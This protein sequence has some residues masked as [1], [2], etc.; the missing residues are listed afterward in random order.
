MALLLPLDWKIE[1]RRKIQVN[2]LIKDKRKYRIVDFCL[3]VFLFM[4]RLKHGQLT[5]VLSQYAFRTAT[6]GGP[7][8]ILRATCSES[9]EAV[10]R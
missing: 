5:S 7:E 1:N 8:N 6:S 10:S 3:S 9:C 4:L 2:P